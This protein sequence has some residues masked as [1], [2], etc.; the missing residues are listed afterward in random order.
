MTTCVTDAQLQNICWLIDGVQTGDMQ[1]P[2]TSFAPHQSIYVCAHVQYSLSH[3]QIT[4]VTE[5]DF[6]AKYTSITEDVYTYGGTLVASFPRLCV[7]FHFFSS[8]KQR[9]LGERIALQ[10]YTDRETDGSVPKIDRD[11]VKYATFCTP[12]VLTRL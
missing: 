5:S 11:A 4:N 3:H 1:M 7:K 10:S 12:S 6:K 8:N 2:I 9:D